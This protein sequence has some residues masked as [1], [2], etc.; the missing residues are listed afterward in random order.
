TKKVDAFTSR[1]LDIHSEMLETNKKEE[2]CLGLHRSDYML[3]AQSQDILQIEL[4]AISCSF[5]GLSCLVSELH[6][7]LTF[8][9]FHFI[10]V[11]THQ[12]ILLNMFLYLLLCHGLNNC[13]RKQS[14]ITLDV[15]DRDNLVKS[16]KLYD[17]QFLDYAE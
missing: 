9:K 3:D 10:C 5:P 14:S 13:S 15:A 12:R 8:C 7:L 2:I 4:N 6:S 1:L 16:L 11:Y 17:V